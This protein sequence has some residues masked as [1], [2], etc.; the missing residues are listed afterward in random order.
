MIKY[1]SIYETVLPSVAAVRPFRMLKAA[2]HFTNYR[3]E[4]FVIIL[5]CATLIYSI[6]YYNHDRKC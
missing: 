2:Q 3:S 5:F 6:R 4:N 1:M